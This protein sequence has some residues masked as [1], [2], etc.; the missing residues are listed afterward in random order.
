MI[1]MLFIVIESF[2]SPEAT[3]AVYQR[4]AERGRMLPEGLQYIDS[5]IE[6]NLNRC[7]QLMETDDP[8]LFE[9]WI[10]CWDDL[11]D[12]E[13]IPVIK[14]SEAAQRAKQTR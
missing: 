5:W 9:E 8:K 2:K 11:V 3:A 6:E 7:F 1:V 13:V 14:S 10:A 4:F 12:L